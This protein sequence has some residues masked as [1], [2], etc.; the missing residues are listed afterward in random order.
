MG[1]GSAEERGLHVWRKPA[2]GS[3]SDVASEESR[4]YDLPLGMSYIR[5]WNWTK[6]IPICPT[7]RQNCVRQR[8]DDSENDDVE[9]AV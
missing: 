9:V 7:F 8:A 3:T 6:F 5:K 4:C 2:D 1:S